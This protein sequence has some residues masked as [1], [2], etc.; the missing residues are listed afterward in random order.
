MTIKH[1]A[2]AAA[3]LALAACTTPTPFQPAANPG[4][5]GY[6]DQRLAENRFR[7]TFTGN[8]ATRRDQVENFL[9]LRSAEVTRDAGY[10]W[11]SSTIATPR[12]RRP[13]SATL[14]TTAAG[15]DRAVTASTGT[16][17][18]MIRSVRR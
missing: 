10:Q 17:G 8:S 7:V 15:G 6:T 11:F 4:G 12:P 16:A 18:P 3:F 14:P 13:I 2:V 1:L 9:L 5:P